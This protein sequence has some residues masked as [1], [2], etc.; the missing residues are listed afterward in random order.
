[1]FS[2]RT[3][4]YANRETDEKGTFEAVVY[5][6]FPEFILK[7]NCKGYFV[8]QD[9]RLPL[10]G[11]GLRAPP[12]EASGLCGAS[13]PRRPRAYPVGDKALL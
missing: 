6:V 1:M 8:S 10:L 13:A 4:G 2:P 3:S 5:A 12:P 7:N 11:D 9:P